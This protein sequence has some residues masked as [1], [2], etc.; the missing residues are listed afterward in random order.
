MEIGSLAF[1]GFNSIIKNA[2]IGDDA[3]VVGVKVPE[4]TVIPSGSVVQMPKDVR[5]LNPGAVAPDTRWGSIKD[6]F[7]V[8][9][10]P[11]LLGLV[12]SEV[13]RKKEH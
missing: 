12:I 10:I 13:L 11:I 4:G 7:L 9:T 1:I 3:I 5:L 8:S 6:I 2:R